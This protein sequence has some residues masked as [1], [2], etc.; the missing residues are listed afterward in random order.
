MNTAINMP[1]LLACVVGLIISIVLNV[2]AKIHI[3]ITSI[4]FAF[5]IGVGML[6]QSTNQILS[7]LPLS[8]IFV[9]M[10]GVPLFNTLAETGMLTILSKR[11]IRATKGKTILLPFACLLAIA[12]IS[13]V[14]ETSVMFVIGPAVAV[15]C[16]LAGIDMMI[17]CMLFS[18]SIPIG[19]ANPWTTVTG[20]FIMG[21]ATANGV[22]DP[23]KMQTA[24]WINM[25]IW[26]VIMVVITLIVF[27]G[28]KNKTIELDMSEDLTFNRDQKI[29]FGIFV[30]TILL[31]SVI[32]V[33]KAAIGGDFLTKL[34]SIINVNTVFPLMAFVAS[35]FKISNFNQQL[36][37]VPWTI[38]VTLS[39]VMLLVGVA[40]NAGLG[41]LLGNFITSNVPVFM[42]PAV[43]V[44]C[45]AGLSF[46]ATFFAVMP[47]LF[48]VAVQV[49]AAT[50]INI[51]I[52]I[53]CICVG[54]IGSGSTSPL[55]AMGAQI[56]SSMPS[57]QQE[58]LAPRM[59]KYTFVSIA[60]YVVLAL[61]GVF[62]IVPNLMGI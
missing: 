54:A 21:L 34:T 24:I 32:P 53:A 19:S 46:V 45:S 43:F 9:F 18:F 22:A 41:T 13:T 59:I 62:N 11:I 12:L 6:G 52:L 55:S 14:A 4:F 44:F 26:S 3:G 27:K 38:I 50:G 33:L 30:T 47:L 7:G 56:L 35:A 61:V 29:A 10:F 8:I 36:Q 48:P 1:A 2:K 25:M 42:V 17:A 39:G 49:S 5:L 57:D 60:I 58:A 16:M 51:S 28:F 15:I 31:L 23:M 40:G 37:R 20:N